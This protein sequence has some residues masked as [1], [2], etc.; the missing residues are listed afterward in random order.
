MPEDKYTASFDF[1]GKSVEAHFSKME[2]GAVAMVRDACRKDD[3]FRAEV[4]LLAGAIDYLA[5]DGEVTIDGRHKKAARQNRPV[6]TNRFQIPAEWDSETM[7]MLDQ[8]LM[9]EIVA[10]EVW[11]AKMEPFSD[12]FGDLL[13]DDERAPK[14]N[15]TPLHRGE[16]AAG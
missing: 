15:P 9:R 1:A 5:I 7:E 3:G 2:S 6:D 8:R 12:I 16:Q 11:P 14:S 4:G 10:H 13:E